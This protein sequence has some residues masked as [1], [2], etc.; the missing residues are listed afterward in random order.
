MF[1]NHGMGFSI[2]SAVGPMYR[3]DWDLTRKE[4]WAD[5]PEQCES[6]ERTDRL[7]VA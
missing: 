5:L 1:P 2:S 3:G 4:R 7:I 6:R